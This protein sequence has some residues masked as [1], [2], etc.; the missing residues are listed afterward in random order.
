MLV[1]RIHLH[2]IKGLDPVRVE[3]A[4]VTA[5]GALELD[6]RW[7]LVDG[8]GRFVNGKNRPG[9]HTIRAE[10]S[11][12]GLEVS[13][14]GRTFSLSRE[15]NA[16]AA[17]FSERLSEPLEWREN[18]EA[19]FPDDTEASGPTFVSAASIAKVAEWFGWPLVTTG[20]RFR[21]NIEFGGTPAFWEDRL[22]GRSFTAGD[23]T[24]DAVNPCARCAVPSRDPFTGQQDNGFQ[25][26]FTEM[27]QANLPPWADPADFKHFYRFTV[28]TRIAPRHAGKTIRVGDPLFSID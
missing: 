21:A 20:L 1:S 17:W 28:N 19:G 8:K 24:V 13:L 27:R 4:R 23:V 10:Y 6:R 9:I 3:E 11:V 7:A 16:I 26:R 14:E 2:P 25:K 12:P 15:G 5:S 18:V 22:Y